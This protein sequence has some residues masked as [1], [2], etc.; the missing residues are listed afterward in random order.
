MGPDIK[1]RILH[2]PA[3]MERRHICL[4]FIFLH[5]RQ[6]VVRPL[7]LLQKGPRLTNQTLT[8]NH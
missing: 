3:I 8:L 4:H 1:Y 5:E 6:A 2:I 7:N